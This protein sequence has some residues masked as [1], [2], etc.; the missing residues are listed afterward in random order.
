[1]RR[2]CLVSGK[3]GAG[4]ST[5][6][7]ALSLLLS[8]RNEVVVYDFDVEEPNLAL[9][10]GARME[11][12][13]VFSSFLPAVEEEKCVRCGDCARVCKPSAIVVLPKGWRVF[14]ELCTGCRVCERAC[15]KG[16]ILPSTRETGEIR[17]FQ[18]D[19]MRIVEGRLRLGVPSAVPLLRELRRRAEEEKADFVVCDGPPGTSCNFVETVK[20]CHLAVVV[21]DPSP[22]GFH[23]GKR[24]V[25]ACE[26]V[27][28]KCA[29]LLNRVTDADAERVKL[30]RSWGVEVV[31]KV[32][33]FEE[34][35]KG[36][37]SPDSPALLDRLSPA[38]TRVEELMRE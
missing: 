3:G 5:V 12:E 23:D 25:E 33:Y 17:V 10:L 32:E 30:V 2:I 34:W 21:L 38:A 6:S 22:F 14:P 19:G 27:G 36:G 28:V 7:A 9:L 1:V 15:S 37:V 24:V 18:R 29:I 20:G 13:E 26:E 16:A 8:L 31:G 35:A 4:K 11:E